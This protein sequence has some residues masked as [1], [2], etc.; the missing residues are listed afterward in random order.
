L[1]TIEASVS[2]VLAFLAAAMAVAPAAVEPLLPIVA[3]LDKNCAG[4]KIRRCV[5]Q[6][7]S[8]RKKKTAAEVG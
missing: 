1:S 4:M 5:S 7:L 3:A 6:E 8:A 2:V